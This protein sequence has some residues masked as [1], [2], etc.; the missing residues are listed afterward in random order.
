MGK[1]GLEGGG[2]VGWVYYCSG[3]VWIHLQ[4]VVRTTF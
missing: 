1:G 2:G 3:D 4:Q